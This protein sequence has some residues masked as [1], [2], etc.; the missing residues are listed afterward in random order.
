MITR[1]RDYDFGLATGQGLVDLVGLRGQRLQVLTVERRNCICGRA[2]IHAEA[3]SDGLHIGVIEDAEHG[4]AVGLG[5]GHVLLNRRV[6]QGLRCHT[7]LRL[8]A[9]R[10]RDSHE[11]NR[12][13]G[14]GLSHERVA[15]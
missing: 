1:G 3:A 5:G 13:N 14:R 15:S 7:G 9:G 12:D 4:C 11:Q 10:K 2:Q 8:N 6:E